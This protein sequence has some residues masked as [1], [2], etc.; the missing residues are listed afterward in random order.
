MVEFVQLTT[1]CCWGQPSDP[2]QRGCL[3]SHACVMWGPRTLNADDDDD[4]HTMTY[5][6]PQS[7]YKERCHN[8]CTIMIHTLKMYNKI[9]PIKILS[10]RFVQHYLRSLAQESTANGGATVADSLLIPT[11]N[12]VVIKRQLFTWI[13][14]MPYLFAWET[15]IEMLQEHF[16]KKN[17]NETTLK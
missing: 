11:T 5:L 4:D 14:K 3:T 12:E 9:S 7:S 2:C 10:Y 16:R 13:T 1:E 8:H 17:E 15:I 6:N